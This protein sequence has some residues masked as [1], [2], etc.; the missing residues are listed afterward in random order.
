MINTYPLIYLG[1]MLTSVLA[2]PLVVK[3][4]RKFNLLDR[5]DPRKVHRVPIPRIGGVAI[6]ISMLAGALP[7]YFMDSELRSDFF[8]NQNQV[9]TLLISSCA[10]FFVGLLDDLFNLPGKVKLVAL[11]L[12]AIAVCNSGV[13]IEHL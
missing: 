1:S 12:A 6:I 10:I 5:P 4:A 2:T 13:K 9:L 11:V 3:V 7:G 8:H